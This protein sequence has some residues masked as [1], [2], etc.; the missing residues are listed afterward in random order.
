MAM[1]KVQYCL[2]RIGA[3]MNKIVPDDKTAF[4]HTFKGILGIRQYIVILMTAIYKQKVNL[5]MIG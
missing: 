1:A 2:N 5:I 4:P 3:I